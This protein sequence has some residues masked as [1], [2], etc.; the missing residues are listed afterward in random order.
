MDMM[1]ES[2]I[3]TTKN[4][5]TLAPKV[6]F[7]AAAPDSEPL[8]DTGS[9][10]PATIDRGVYNRELASIHA[11]FPY[12]L[13]RG[14]VNP[15]INRPID[16]QTDYDLYCHCLALRRMC[17]RELLAA[18]AAIRVSQ[19]NEAAA[20]R[21]TAHYKQGLSVC[22]QNLSDC[23]RALALSRKKAVALQRDYE[24]LLTRIERRKVAF[25]KCVVLA[26][27]ASL[28]VFLLFFNSRPVNNVADTQSASSEASSYSEPIADGPSRPDGYVSDYYIGN[29]TSHKFHRTTCSYLPDEGNQCK[30]K[31]RDAAV[32]AGYSPCGHCNP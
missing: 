10:F 24:T 28:F 1:T 31:S 21:E 14:R 22:E 27:L 26:F 20:K 3:E 29:K 32:S 2:T 8:I 19:Q 25:S 7:S 12:S 16:T 17:D 5:T 4:P 11:E 18:S 23:K 30:F 9:F 6:R 13:I 15:Y